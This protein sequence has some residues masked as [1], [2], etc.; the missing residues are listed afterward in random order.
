MIKRRS[1]LAAGLALPAVARAQTVQ[2][3]SF[4]YPIA[5]G[6]PIP[7]II[8]GYCKEFQAATGI[9]VTPVYAGN[10][11]ETLT[12]AVT[13]IKGGQ[14]PQMAVLLA[15]EMHSLQDLGILVSL[16][17]IGLDAAGKAW[18]DGFYPAF[19]ANSHAEGKLWSVPFQRS[20]AVMYYNKAAFAEAGL[21]PEAFPKTWAQLQTAATK[22][23]KRDATGRVTRWGVKMAGD[24]GN[25]QWT[26]GALANQAGH[27]LMNQA[28]TEA[29]FNSP[30]A[31]EALAYWQGLATVQKA[32]PD[33]VSNWPQL[34]PDFLEGNAAIIQHTTGNLTNVRTNAKFPFGVAGLPGRDGPRTVVGGGN[35]YFFKNATPAERV[36]SLKFARFMSE[37]ARAADWSIKTGYIATRPEAYET[38]ALKDYVAGFPPADVARGFL[39]V[40]VGEL[41]TFE[42]QKV[43]AALTNNVQACLNGTK[44][45]AAA[46]ADTQAEADR[47][48][49][50]YKKA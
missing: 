9:E 26:F 10:Y 34:S 47:I 20:T 12:K 32:S 22:L 50:P 45:A 1:L 49:K 4:Y 21:D 24:T 19:L 17:E 46:M 18:M 35:L 37:P 7:A 15:A 39:P 13:A 42:N 5:V 23:T 33:G 25:A 28:G 41:S 31:V 36:A 2:K 14:G 16:D 29:Y 27:V 8:D 43:Y 38:K 3:L 48:L 11:G 44:T 30:K 40:A 6:G